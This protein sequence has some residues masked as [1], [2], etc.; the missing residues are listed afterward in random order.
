LDRK[1]GSASLYISR[2]VMIC[3]IGS[4]TQSDDT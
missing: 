3:N 4:V 1:S 2:I